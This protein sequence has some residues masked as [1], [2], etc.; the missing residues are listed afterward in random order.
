MNNPEAISFA[1]IDC[2]AT[3]ESADPVCWL[4]DNTVTAVSLPANLSGRTGAGSP[5]ALSGTGPSRWG[6]DVLAAQA[7][8]L[9]DPRAPHS[10]AG[11]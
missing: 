4:C 5:L 11:R 9:P 7:L 1:C 3:W 8:G 2:E 6:T 10:A